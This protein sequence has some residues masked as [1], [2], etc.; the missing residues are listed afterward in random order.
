M[1]SVVRGPHS[2]RCGYGKD[3]PLDEVEPT[4]RAPD[5]RI[6]RRADVRR[7]F[8]SVSKFDRAVALCLI[9]HSA[10]ETLAPRC[11]PCD[12]I[13]R[14]R[15]ATYGVHGDRPGARA[16]AVN[17]VTRPIRSRVRHSARPRRLEAQL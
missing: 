12:R 10:V 17:S 14:G 16:W 13:S 6:E 11:V 9:D 8:A 2:S 4:L 15:T 5:E 1:T 3:K 7:V